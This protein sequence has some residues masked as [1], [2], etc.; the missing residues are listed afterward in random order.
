M[1]G[2]EIRWAVVSGMA[3]VK[4]MPG[5]VTPRPGGVVDREPGWAGLCVPAAP[6][7]RFH[8]GDPFP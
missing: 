1:T 4:P 7:V 2:R 8:N 3:L 5:N 6:G